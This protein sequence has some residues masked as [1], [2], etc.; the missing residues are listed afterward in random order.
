MG[1]VAFAENPNPNDQ[2]PGKPNRFRRKAQ[3]P[4]PESQAKIN[5]QKPG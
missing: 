5:Y 1:H 2:I 3:I 4:K